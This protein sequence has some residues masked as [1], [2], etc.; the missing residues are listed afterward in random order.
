VSEEKSAGVAEA[1][2]SPQD[3]DD[4]T[5]T[6][7]PLE[8]IEA[9]T[10]RDIEK[11]KALMAH[12]KV[13]LDY[14]NNNKNAKGLTA[15]KIACRNGRN[16]IDIEIQMLF[17][18]IKGVELPHPDN[19]LYRSYTP[20]NYIIKLIRYDL[21][22]DELL[23]T[24][25]MKLI[26]QNDP[27]IINARDDFGQGRTAL[28]MAVQCEWL[29][30]LE[31]LLKL[32]C[33]KQIINAQ[34]VHYYETALFKAAKRSWIEGVR[35]LVAAKADVNL[36]SNEGQTALTIAIDDKSTELLQELLVGKPNLDVEMQRHDSPLAY[37][38]GWPEGI[39]LLLLAKADINSQRPS[40]GN[41]ALMNAVRYQSI[42]DYDSTMAGIQELL[43]YK[44]INLDLT[45]DEGDT[46]LIAAA[47]RTID[48]ESGSRRCFGGIKELL[49]HK[50]NLFV[51]NKADKT[52]L[53]IINDNIDKVRLNN[54]GDQALIND[55]ENIRN[56]LKSKI[57]DYTTRLNFMF[58]EHP[59]LGYASSIFRAKGSA[60]SERNL[61][62]IIFDL[63]TSPESLP[64]SMVDNQHI[65]NQLQFIGR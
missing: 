26:Q 11:V 5:S 37:S 12:P 49:K 18:Q 28:M 42:F 58:G 36:Q 1:K 9:V 45:N 6:P 51:K 52:V 17:V 55:L 61:F 64:T 10:A 34:T 43:K 24:T 63:A 7:G 8:L 25:A 60:L 59:R 33:I 41:T 16:Y 62:R 46:A 50:C 19:K 30:I 40:N 35:A 53:D 44:E 39:K 22:V 4:F 29:E 15:W 48:F 14:I 23:R 20:L 32:D 57:V 65:R 27:D 38:I 56:I 31:E 47:K 54:S 21:G 2:H 13:T 3:S